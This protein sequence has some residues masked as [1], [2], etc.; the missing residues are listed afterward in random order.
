MV[1][2]ERTYKEGE[3]YRTVIQKKDKIIAQYQGL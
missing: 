2:E 1:I 3:T